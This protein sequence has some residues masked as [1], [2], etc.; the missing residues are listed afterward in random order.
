MKILVTGGAGFIASHIV[1]RYIELGHDVIVV[2]NLSS[3]RKDF[4][5]KKASFYNIDIREKENIERVFADEQ[6]DILNHHAAQ[7]SVRNSVTDPLN[8]AQV[9]ILGL[10]NLLEAGRKNGLKKVVIASSGG[11]VYGEAKTIPTPEDY[12]PK[13][14]LSPYGVSKLTSEKYLYYYFKNYNIPYMALRYANVYGPRQN[15]HGEAGV[16][17]IFSLKMLKG[18]RPTINGD[19]NQTRDYIYITDVVDVNVKALNIKHQGS[20]NIGT[21]QETNVNQLYEM[22]KAVAKNNLSPL[23]APSRKGEQRR[24]CLDITYAREKIEW[25]PEINLNNGLNLTYQYFKKTNE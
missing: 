6:P 8:D 4:I 19:G 17:A 23:Y 25:K 16:V 18:E 5:N 11:V 2:D 21:S 15:P 9:N 22:L 20:I 1:D 14:P 24:S 13:N 7:I 10:L 12:E 3:G